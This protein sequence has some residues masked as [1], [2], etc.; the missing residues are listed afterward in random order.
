[1]TWI[2]T[3]VMLQIGNLYFMDYV[4]TAIA[5]KYGFAVEGNP[6]GF[7]AITGLLKLA[8]LMLI[9]LIWFS[10][11]KDKF[12]LKLAIFGAVAVMF[13]YMFIIMNN[14]NVLLG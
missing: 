10:F 14:I 3:V 1:M 2:F 8:P 12:G 5:L 13:L 6:L 7:S 11:H 9:P 4:L